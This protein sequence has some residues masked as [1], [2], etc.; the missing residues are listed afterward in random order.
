ML[1][2]PLES[3]EESDVSFERCKPLLPLFLASLDD[4]F[5]ERLDFFSD[6]DEVDF[7]LDLPLLTSLGD[8]FFDELGIFPDLDEVDLESDLP[9]LPLLL[10]SLLDEGD[11]FE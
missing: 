10:E 9:V 7:E 11:D 2:L 8:L 3:L 5:F 6:F 1:K 4:P